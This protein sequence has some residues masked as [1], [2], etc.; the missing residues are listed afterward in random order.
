MI[1]R[2]C[3]SNKNRNEIKGNILD[4]KSKYILQEIFSNLQ[5]N[6]LLKIIKYNKKIQEKLNKDIKD[7]KTYVDIII[8][9]IPINKRDK[10]YFIDK[11]E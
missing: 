5:E 2:K 3:S 4:I 11:Y 7:Y 1:I 9:I 8:E 6:R 10:N